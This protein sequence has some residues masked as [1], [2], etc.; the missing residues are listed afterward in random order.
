MSDPNQPN[1]PNPSQ[2]SSPHQRSKRRRRGRGGG[3]HRPNHHF[4]NQNN[5]PQ[6]NPDGTQTQ[7]A[8]AGNGPNSVPQENTSLSLEDRCVRQFPRIALGRGRAYFNAGRVSDPVWTEKEC[9]VE[10]QGSGGNYKVS[11]DF[12]QVPEARRLPAKCDCPAYAKGVLCKHLWAGILQ[13]EKASPAGM[14]PEGGSLKLV[15]AQPRPRREMQG[16]QPGGHGPGGQPRPQGPMIVPGRI[17]SSWI[18]RLNQL[19]GL[20]VV[21]PERRLAASL[22]AFFVISA[23]ETAS[24]GKLVFDLWT[25]VKSTSGD[26]GP[27]RPNRVSGHDFSHYDDLRD[28]EVLTLLTRSG[29]P[30][31]F[32]PYGG[33]GGNVSSRFT[34]DPIFESHLI[35]MLASAGKLFLSRSPNGTPDSA[36][37]PLRLDRSKTYDLELKIE[38]PSTEYYKLDAILKRSGEFLNLS[39]PLAILRSGFLL[40]DDRLSRFSEPAHALW[41]LALRKPAQFLVPRADGD[42]LLTRILLDPSSPKVTWPADMGWTQ[43]LIEP[44]PKGVFRPLGNDPSTGRMTLTVSFDYDGREVALAENEKTL[45]D[46]ANKRVIIRN[47]EFEERTLIKA[48]EILRDPQGTGS[49]PMS[50][51]HRAANDLCRAGWTIHFENQKLLIADDFALNVSSSTDW[52]DLKMS[53]SFGDISVDQRQLLAALESGSGL[54]KLSDGS[55]GMLPPEW[56][57]QYA[58]VAQLGTKFGEMTEDGNLRF[59]RFQGLML[60]AVLTDDSRLKADAGFSAFREKIRKFE[61]MKSVA[62][63]SGFKGKL[64]DY[65]KEGLAWLG[66]IQEFETGGILADDMGLG[67]TIQVL[68]FL[69]GRIASQKDGQKLPCLVVTPK[70]LAF[71]WADEASRFAPELKLVRYAGTGRTKLID[72]MKDADVVVTTYGTLRTDIK[73]LQEVEFDVAIVDEAQAIK[74]SKSQAAMAAKKLRARQKLALTGTPIEN[75]IKDL[76]SILEFTNPGLLTVSPQKEIGHDTQAMLAKT[77]KPFM[78]RRTKE[79]VLTE[80]PDKSEQVLFCEMSTT[81]KQFYAAIRD[82]YR[83]SLAEKI[84]SG[85][86]LAKNKLHVLEALLRLRQ[87]ACHPGLVDPR[88][89]GEPSAKLQLLLNHIKEVTQEGHKALVFSQFTSLLSLVRTNLE[90]EGV[91][92]EYLDGQTEDRKTPVERFQNDPNSRVF[93]ISLKAGGTGLNLTAAD[94]V[95]ILD[96]WWNPAVEA[97][98]IGRA[99]RMGQSNKVFA[100]RM[101]ARGTVEEKILELQKTKKD[102]AESIISE[103]QDFLRKLTKDDLEQLLT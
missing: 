80:L 50:D 78:L 42:S 53:A 27:L 94:Y 22:S 5:Q 88:R 43:T 74:N 82:K 39:A 77:L 76:I 40:F 17:S 95:F 102:L 10:V 23:D 100:Y 101:I 98:A 58:P 67:K 26:M 47:T 91:H 51:L 45:V 3:H 90:E 30:Q 41:A 96:P 14:I 84:D 21:A 97:Q 73:K 93:L 44:K 56:L 75:S 68:A 81:E 92:Y 86:G 24:S 89:K 19:Q 12:S 2:P 59:T 28:Q 37:R 46:P 69:L 87:A 85:G 16:P 79:K 9:S 15:H 32:T 36:E 66:F 34:V 57:A 4:Q 71:N 33:R 72:E 52:F 6:T 13:V 55:L 103:D 48:L 18:D 49:V 31:T 70:S 11:F 20:S 64:R 38:A 35:P 54:V 65:Q 83:A 99:H 1:Q 29:N 25:R 60:N 8:N 61:G 62:A 7:P 63:P